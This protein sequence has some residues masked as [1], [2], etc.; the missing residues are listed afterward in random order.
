MNKVKKL[1][2]YFKAKKQLNKLEPKEI[3]Y[4]SFSGVEK[5]ARVFKVYDGDTISLLFK[6]KKQNIKASCRLLGI[7]TPEL[8]TKNENEKKK[9]IEARDFLHNLIY[10]KI[11]LVK[12]SKN[13][14]FG[15]PLIE[16][17]LP[18]G[19]SISQ[20]MINKK[21]AK[22]YLGKSKKNLWNFK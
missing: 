11:V 4:F 13:G 5:Y 12:F 20:I 9:A 7:D 1:Y 2:K 14:K 18:S 6:W 21:Y 15:R 16:V 19:E 3:D 8:R 10:E 17:F 22:K